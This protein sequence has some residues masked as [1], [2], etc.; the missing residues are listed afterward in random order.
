MSRKIT[1]AQRPYTLLVANLTQGS[2]P[3]RNTG[4]NPVKTRSAFTYQHFPEVSRP[5]PEQ[6]NT[7]AVGLRTCVGH[8]AYTV[9]PIPVA[10]SVDITVVSTDFSAPVCLTFGNYDLISGEDYVVDAG[11]DYVGEDLTSTAPDTVITVWK[12]AGAGLGEGSLLVPAN[13]PI[14]PGSVTLHWISGGLP[15][16]QV[17][18][19]AGG[20]TGDGNPALSSIDYATGAITLDTTPLAADLVTTITI[21]YS[22]VVTTGDIATNL[23]AAVN[24]L[25]GLSS[26]ALF[27]VVTVRGSAGPEGNN[28]Q[29][30][31]VYGGV[32]ENFT[33]VPNTGTLVGAEPTIGPPIITP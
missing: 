7:P 25:P 1:T 18:D 12:T 32:V 33:L 24:A 17:D 15:S 31:A 10:G 30:E 26:S 27:A 3:S 23:A 11:I 16:S 5:G 21:D 14:Q 9:A 29:V 19:G 28:T 20:F 13:L 8:V 6:E 4:G 22:G 2:D